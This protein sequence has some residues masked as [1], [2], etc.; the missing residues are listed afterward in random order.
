M[1]EESYCID[2][3]DPA[4]TFN[5]EGGELAQNIG[6]GLIAYKPGS[7]NIVPLLAENYTVSPDGKAYTFWIHP[8]ITSP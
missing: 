6:Q 2:S 8:N 4:V 5:G 1:V 3:L 7:T